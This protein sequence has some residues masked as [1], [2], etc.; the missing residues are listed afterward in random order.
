MQLMHAIGL[1]FFL[2]ILVYLGV[3]NAAGVASIFNAGGTQGVNL[4]KALQG[5]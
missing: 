2:L 4:T 1:G 3:T 5:R